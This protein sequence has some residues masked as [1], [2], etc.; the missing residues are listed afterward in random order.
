MGLWGRDPAWFSRLVPHA[1]LLRDMLILCVCLMLS[2][3]MPY[4]NR[5]LPEQL[6]IKIFYRFIFYG[7][8]LKGIDSCLN[9]H[10]NVYGEDRLKYNREYFT[11]YLIYI[12]IILIASLGSWSL[13]V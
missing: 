4:Y 2:T 5:F 11:A 8:Q 6:I 7:M 10:Y 12:C 1:P 3:I 13:V 9:I